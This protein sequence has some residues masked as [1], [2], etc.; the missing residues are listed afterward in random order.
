MTTEAEDLLQSGTAAP[1]LVLSDERVSRLPEPVARYLHL[2]NTV[3]KAIR[4]VR[5]EQSGTMRMTPTA[6]WLPFTAVET[7]SVDPPGFIW[8]AQFRPS[9]FA[10]FFVADMFVNGQ[11]RLRVKAYNLVKMTDARVRNS[12]KANW[13][14]IWPRAFGY[15]R[16]G[17]RIGSRGM[18]SAPAWRPR[19]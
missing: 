12:I 8:E 7:M 9:R 2:T 6:K 19:P 3:G 17:Y 16:C 15:R 4:A 5:L 11:G 18:P 14:A 10:S 1:P 13:C